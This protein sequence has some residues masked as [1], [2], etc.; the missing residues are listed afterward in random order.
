MNAIIFQPNIYLKQ[1]KQSLTS[2]AHLRSSSPAMSIAGRV[3]HSTWQPIRTCLHCN[4]NSKTVFVT[5]LLSDIIFYFAKVSSM[6]RKDV[7]GDNIL[8]VPSEFNRLNR[9]KNQ[10]KA[11]TGNS[12]QGSNIL[13][14]E[15]QQHYAHCTHTVLFTDLQ[16]F[17]YKLTLGIN[18]A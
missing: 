7:Y 14:C 17:H 9:N 15:K 10:K 4:N 1:R 2:L 11:K 6:P 18:L 5:R 12:Q 8:Q 3:T 16:Y 13:Y